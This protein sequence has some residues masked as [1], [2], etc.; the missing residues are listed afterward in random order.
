MNPG[1][2]RGVSP[3]PPQRIEVSVV[4]RLV[5]GEAQITVD[6]EHRLAELGFEVDVRR[7]AVAQG[8]A[9]SVDQPL[10][11]RGNLPVVD[12][13]VLVEVRLAVVGSQ[14]V[15]EIECLRPEA[16]KGRNGCHQ[17]LILC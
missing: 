6:S 11:R 16:G 3:L 17:P 5:L 7:N 8:V 9:H 15:E 1:P 12:R 10:Q 2:V 13:A 4:R 14:P